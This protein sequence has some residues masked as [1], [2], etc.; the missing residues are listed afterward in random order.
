MVCEKAL[1]L[2]ELIY[3]VTREFPA[4][5]RLGLTTHVRRS[6]IAVPAHIVEGHGLKS[7]G[8][9]R[10]HLS[11]AASSVKE[12]EIDLEIADRLG[13]LREDVW[14]DLMSLTD[15]IGKMLA[16]LQ[17]SAGPQSRSPTLQ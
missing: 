3:T 11:V 9:Y 10:Q 6:A 12:V 17:N 8:A 15:E 1:A 4:E 13:Y 7:T 16:G 5:E 2:V 14:I